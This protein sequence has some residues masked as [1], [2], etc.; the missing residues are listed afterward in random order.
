M[1]QFVDLLCAA[2]EKAGSFG[3]KQCDFVNEH[4]TILPFVIYS[5]VSLIKMRYEMIVI[6]QYFRHILYQ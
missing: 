6:V 2:S 3:R 4:Y 5:Y 1:D